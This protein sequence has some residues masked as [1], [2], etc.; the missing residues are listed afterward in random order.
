MTQG[1]AVLLAHSEQGSFVRPLN[2]GEGR[3]TL[4][5]PEQKRLIALK[6]GPSQVHDAQ[7][8]A[9]SASPVSPH[10]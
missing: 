1:P 3:G 7:Q 9:V 10:K 6:D 4:G 2:G 5:S 8:K